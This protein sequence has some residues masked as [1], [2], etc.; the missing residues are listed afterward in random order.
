MGRK[1]INIRIKSISNLISL[2]LAGC[3]AVYLLVVVVVVY[4][5][6]TDRESQLAPVKEN[7]GPSESSSQIKR[8]IWTRGKSSEYLH[9]E[10]NQLS[11]T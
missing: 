10:L 7:R 6:V 8:L 5:Q 1:I 11:F 4:F 2:F 3:R 9:N